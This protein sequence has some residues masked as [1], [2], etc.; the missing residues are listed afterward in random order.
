MLNNKKNNGFILASILIF[1]TISTLLLSLLLNYNIQ[2]NV[3]LNTY[4]KKR[5]T[6]KQLQRVE[7]L[8]NYLIH[9]NE[10]R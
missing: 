8:T 5:A 4:I 10:N 3:N 7:K 9:T 6:Q 2:N 1:L